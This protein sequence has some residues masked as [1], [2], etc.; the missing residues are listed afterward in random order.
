MAIGPKATRA[1]AAA[2]AIVGIAV[3]C[4]VAKVWVFGNGRNS[5]KSVWTLIIS[6]RWTLG[7]L[8]VAIVALGLYAAASVAALIASGRWIMA[9]STTG[10]EADDP[11]AVDRL[12]SLEA[13]TRE[14]R[15][16]RDQAYRLLEEYLHG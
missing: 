16:E 2:V 1:H 13:R 6:D 12:A 9:L 8:R 15:Q 10:F 5:A 7:F 3:G 4:A 11:Q 14:L